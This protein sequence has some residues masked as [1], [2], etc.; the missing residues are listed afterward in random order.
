MLHLHRHHLHLLLCLVVISLTSNPTISQGQDY[1]DFFSHNGSFETSESD[2]LHYDVNYWSSPGRVQYRSND[3]TGW[4]LFGENGAPRWVT[5]SAQDGSHYLELRT[6][7]ISGGT[8]NFASIDGSS[9]LSTPFV[10]GEQYE[11]SFWAAGAGGAANALSVSVGSGGSMIDLPETDDLSIPGPDWSQFVIPFVPTSSTIS[12]TLSAVRD[13]N[14]IGYSSSVYV[15]NFSIAHVPEP[16][17]VVLV[18]AGG[19][20]FFTG[21]RR[22]PRRKFCP[23]V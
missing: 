19:V 6:T 17:S 23:L 21:R 14:Y 12:L 2:P 18:M 15:D 20:L 13:G 22:Q 16:G 7:Y 3:L 8:H 4:S 11:L 5:G 9:L 1:S 10:A